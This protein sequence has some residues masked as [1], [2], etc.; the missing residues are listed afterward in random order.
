MISTI[1][2]VIL[3]AA[4]IGVLPAW[5]Y[6]RE[7]GLF[8]SGGPILVVI[9][10]QVLVLSARLQ[11]FPLNPIPESPMRNP[12]GIVLVLVGVILLVLGVA[13]SESVAS[14]FSKFFTGEP[15]D[16]SI[17]LMIGGVVAIGLG[18]GLGWRSSRT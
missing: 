1:I 11:L 6:S 17:W 7:W 18:A 3:I 15:S 10:L 5:P 12:I 16:R 2:L 13:A 14:S 4:L 8:P 9:I